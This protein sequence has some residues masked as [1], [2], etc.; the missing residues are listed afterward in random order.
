MQYKGSLKIKNRVTYDPA[1][2]FMHKG[3]G[4]GESSNLKRYMHPNVHSDTVYNRQ[5]AA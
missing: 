3:S 4:K 2:P 1:I 5:E